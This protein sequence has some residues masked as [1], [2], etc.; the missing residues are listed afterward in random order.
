MN[1]T[2]IPQRIEIAFWVT[3][4]PMMEES[5]ELQ[6]IMKESY[7]LITRM[8][9]LSYLVRALALAAIGLSLGFGFGYLAILFR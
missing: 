3:V 4:I 6:A 7:R 9:A 2:R 5:S 8:K 1:I